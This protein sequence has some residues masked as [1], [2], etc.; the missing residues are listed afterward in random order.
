MLGK[1][2]ELVEGVMTCGVESV[3][4]RGSLLKACTVVSMQRENLHHRTLAAPHF[5]TLSK[6]RS[7]L[8]T[9]YRTTKKAW[10]KRSITTRKQRL[11]EQFT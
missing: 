6:F 10:S 2:S 1:S 7:Q 3:S 9:T 11:T 4:A 8:E 5:R